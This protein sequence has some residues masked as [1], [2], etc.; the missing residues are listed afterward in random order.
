MNR[1]RMHRQWGR[2]RYGFLTGIPLAYIFIA[3]NVAFFILQEGLKASGITGGSIYSA[4][5]LI[6]LFARQNWAITQDLQIWRLITP[7]FF[8]VGL[9][10]LAANGL[11]LYFIGAPIEQLFG[12]KGFLWI[13]FVSG[14]AGNLFGFAFAPGPR[15][16]SV[17]ASGAIFGLLGALLYHAILL[18]K[19]GQNNRLLINVGFIFLL[20]LWIGLQPG[21]GIDNFAHAGGAIGGFLVAFWIAKT[22][23][24]RTW[25]KKY[26]SMYFWWIW[27]MFVFLL[28][29]GFSRILWQ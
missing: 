22:M 3:I 11:S 18:R 4:D 26:G 17:G 21:S 2:R 6:D 10:H 14:I 13:Y 5:I 9:M 19:A 8:H 28:I 12:K 27:A 24:V 23:Y 7:I 1:F 29:L 25:Q 20:N 16:P 15:T